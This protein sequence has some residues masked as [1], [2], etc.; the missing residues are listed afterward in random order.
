VTL[1]GVEVIEIAGVNEFGDFEDSHSVDD[2]HP[3]TQKLQ[4]VRRE[5]FEIRDLLSALR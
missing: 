4:L 3:A 1:D 5:L 2:S